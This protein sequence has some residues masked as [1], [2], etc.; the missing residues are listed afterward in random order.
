MAR[1]KGRP[2]K[3]SAGQEERETVIHM[4][5]SPSYVAWLDGIHRSTHIP[6]V[7]IVRLAL[8]E[9]AKKHS[10]PEPPEI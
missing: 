8:A 4:K 10:H 3:S 6:K 1:P 2:L 7:Q 5:G 9:W